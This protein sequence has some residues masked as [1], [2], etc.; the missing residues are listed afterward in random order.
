M[1]RKVFF[2]FH[3]ERDAWRA[4]Q[5][6]NSGVTQDEAGFLDAASWEEVKKKGSDAVIK[7]IKDQLLGTSV[8]VVLIGAQTSNR[9]YVKYELEQS[10]KRGNGILGVYIHQLKNA[11]GQ[12]DTK[13]SNQFGEIFASYGD[14]KKYFFQRFHS[15]DWVDNDGYTNFDNWIETAASNAGK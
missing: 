3:F 4:G 15:Y 10:W 13:G 5:V 14:D 1:T 8:T 9:T 12:T 2:S 6:R 7:W 11:Q